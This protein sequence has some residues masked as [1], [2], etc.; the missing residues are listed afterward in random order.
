MRP[1]VARYLEGADV[2][3]P[4]RAGPADPAGGAG[5]LEREPLRRQ[6]VTV[7]DIND[8]IVLPGRFRLVGDRVHRGLGGR[9]PAPE[10]PGPLERIARQRA[11]PDHGRS[12]SS[13]LMASARTTGAAGSPAAAAAAVKTS[14]ALPIASARLTASTTSCAP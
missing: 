7:P 6:V 5:M 11:E 9:C 1:G 13:S 4:L 8:R 3:A 14:V 12:S 10:Q 2:H